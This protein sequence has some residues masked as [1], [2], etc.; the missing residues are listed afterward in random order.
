MD[1]QIEQTLLPCARCEQYR[2]RQQAQPLVSM[3][4]SYPWE[5]ASCDLFAYNGR[6]H[7]VMK[8]RFSGYLFVSGPLS[9]E[10]TSTVIAF[11]RDCCKVPAYPGSIRTDN[12]PCFRDEF[13]S[14][15]KTHNINHETSDPM[16]P[17]GNG[18]AES[19]VAQAEHL[20]D[21]VN[22]KYDGEFIEALIDWN[23]AARADGFSPVAM[24]M[25]RRL[26]TRMPAIHSITM[27][28]ELKV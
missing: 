3:P 18:H 15:C 17:K 25:G 16:R 1:N 12:G 7:A 22:G 21:R 19:A 8:D 20:L 24:F 13:T 2:P 26:R 23:N 14:W 6:H 5:S 9:N 11:V 10:R 4:A 27:H 28:L